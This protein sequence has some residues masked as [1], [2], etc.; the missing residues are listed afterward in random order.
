MRQCSTAQAAKLLGVG[1]AT[2]HR[3]IREGKV[4]APHRSK[5]GGVAVRLWTA[6][7]LAQIR[8]YKKACYQKG[9]GRK[10]AH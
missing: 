8:S 9:H 2:L 4:P 3:W 5:V 7:D 10:P 6:D 1:R